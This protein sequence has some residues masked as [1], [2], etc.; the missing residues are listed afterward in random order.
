MVRSWVG[1]VKKCSGVP[2]STITPSSTMITRSATSLANP[3]SWVTQT[4]VIPPSASSF[5]TDRTS[6]IVS[7][8]SALVGSSKSMRVG[9]IASARAIATRCC[10]PPESR[11]GYASFFSNRPTRR[12]SDSASAVAC[13]TEAPRTRT[14]ASMMFSIAVLWGHRLKRWNTKP[15]SER[16]RAMVRSASSSSVPSSRSRYPTR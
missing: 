10:C 8:S 16:L 13:A 6:P 12:R 11:A 5:I 3:I 9:C 7:G 1:D 14:G 15:I 2:S 4:I